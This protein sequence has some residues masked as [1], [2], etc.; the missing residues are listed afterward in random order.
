MTFIA[1]LLL[2]VPPVLADEETASSKQESEPS[3][4]VEL[5]PAFVANYGS[6]SRLHYLKTEISLRV[7]DLGVDA[8]RHHMPAIRHEII[9]LLSRQDNETVNSAQGK[10]SIRKQALAV[11][12]E[13][14]AREESGLQIDDLLFTSF[15][16]QR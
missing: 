14:L 12:Q 7:A 11:V 9:M 2:F 4:Y 13:A 1:L 10:E 6:G 3:S 15:I 5:F 8:V 16:I